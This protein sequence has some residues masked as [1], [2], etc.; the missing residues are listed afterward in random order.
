LSIPFAK[1]PSKFTISSITKYL[2]KSSNSSFLKL[3]DISEKIGI[4][5]EENLF[6]LKIAN[7]CHIETF[8]SFYI[9]VGT[10]DSDPEKSKNKFFSDTIFFPKNSFLL[11]GDKNK[12]K[13]LTPTEIIASSTGKRMFSYSRKTIDFGSL[14]EEKKNFTKKELSNIWRNLFFIWFSK[15]YVFKTGGKAWW[16]SR[17]YNDFKGGSFLLSESSDFIFSDRHISLNAQCFYL[18]ISLLRSS[19]SGGKQRRKEVRKKN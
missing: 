15:R 4:L 18:Q 8:G 5:S 7:I 13:T 17:Y 6:S 2:K 3:K 10:P 12:E 11:H 19:L 16:E 14:L 9:L 1:F